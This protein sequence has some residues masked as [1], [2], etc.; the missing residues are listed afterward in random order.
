MDFS[1]SI[2]GIGDG[3][4]PFIHDE[5]IMMVFITA[6]AQDDR[7]IVLIYLLGNRTNLI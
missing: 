5:P 6:Y 2:L 7:Q 1:V 4:N 3:R